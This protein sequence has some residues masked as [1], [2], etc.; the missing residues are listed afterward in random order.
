MVEDQ[1]AV[2]DDT[3]L[4][5]DEMIGYLEQVDAGLV[6]RIFSVCRHLVERRNRAGF[7]A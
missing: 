7:P 3:D 4:S 5:E 1:K 2:S 6:G